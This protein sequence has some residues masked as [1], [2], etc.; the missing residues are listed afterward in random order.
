MMSKIQKRA[1][2]LAAARDRVTR[3][4]E[5]AK[6]ARDNVKLAKMDSV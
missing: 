3:C 1:M 4:E 5:E 6:L 2:A